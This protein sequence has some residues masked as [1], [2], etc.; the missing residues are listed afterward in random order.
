MENKQDKWI[1]FSTVYTSLPFEHTKKGDSYINLIFT[2][3]YICT[4]LD[5]TFLKKIVTSPV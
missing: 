3:Y 5:K 2:P 4:F 1:H